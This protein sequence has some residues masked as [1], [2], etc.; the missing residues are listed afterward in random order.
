MSGNMNSF[1]V[2]P[3]A[4][5]LLHFLAYFKRAGHLPLDKAL[6]LIAYLPL[7]THTVPLLQGLGSLETLYLMVEK[8]NE[9][10]LTKKL[11]VRRKENSYIMA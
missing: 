3:V 1:F 11:A 4:P 9:V 5:N 2:L 6:D 7:E 8:R 10:D